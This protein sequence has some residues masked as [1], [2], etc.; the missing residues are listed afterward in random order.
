[1]HGP[2][3][4]KKCCVKTK[5]DSLHQF[6]FKHAYCWNKNTR[7]A[8]GSNADCALEDRKNKRVRTRSGRSG[9]SGKAGQRGAVPGPPR[10][11]GAP[12]RLLR[13]SEQAP[14][15][16]RVSRTWEILGVLGFPTF[17][18]G[19]PHPGP[20]LRGPPRPRAARRPRGGRAGSPRRPGA[21]RRGGPAG[22]PAVRTAPRSRSSG[23]PVLRA[24]GG[25][26]LP[27][28]R[29]G[30][31][32]S[33][34]GAGGGT[35]GSARGLAAP[36]R[37]AAGRRDGVGR[38][39]LP[40]ARR[41]VVTGG[42]R[43]RAEPESGGS[44]GHAGGL[45]ELRPGTRPRPGGADPPLRAGFLG[46]SRTSA[47]S[48]GNF[49]PR[50]FCRRRSGPPASSRGWGRG[51]SPARGWRSGTGRP[52]ERYPSCR[53]AFLEPG[54]RPLQP[55]AFAGPADAPRVS[56]RSPEGECPSAPRFG[57]PPS[58]RTRRGAQPPASRRSR[59]GVVTVAMGTAGPRPP[60]P[61][62][63]EAVKA[64]QRASVLSARP[65]RV[66]KAR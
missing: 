44:S 49:L 48:A 47:R 63:D 1:M 30:G 55:G 62:W 20:G 18:S 41:A 25:A 3:L 52:P 24:E 23:P 9:L 32:G 14:A 13:A 34:P 8:C 2:T 54:G 7:E 38:W 16:P 36:A 10:R 21:G 57:Q 59:G 58:A 4:F 29:G 15:D 28:P 56:A 11:R 37:P 65:P 5:E 27:A 43:R 26:S 66:S 50:S 35:P 51:A 61:R 60:A 64:A 33:I 6:H 45:A 53:R 22:L 12:Q 39:A 40:R 31:R 19:P 42:R 17:P 46:C